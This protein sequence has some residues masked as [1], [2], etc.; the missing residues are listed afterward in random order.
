LR[1]L[2]LVVPVLTGCAQVIGADFNGLLPKAGSGGAA[3]SDQTGGAGGGA[4]D[5][6]SGGGGA[7][8]GGAAGA[9][10]NVMEDASADATGDGA[11][12][13]ATTDRADAKDVSADTMGDGDAPTMRDATTDLI[14]T[15]VA[16]ADHA[17]AVVPPDA[18]VT[19]SVIINEIKGVGSGPDWIELHNPGQ[20]PMV[21]DG[22][23]VAQAMGSTGPPDLVGALTFPQG[24][25]LDGGAFLMVVAQ[26]ATAGGPTTACQALAASCFTVTWG[27]SSAGERMYLLSPASADAA[28]SIVEQ[29]DY[30]A[31]VVAGQTWARAANGTFQVAAPTPDRPNGI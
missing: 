31:T 3:G 14:G 6:V 26:Q 4:G 13:D 30:P 10:G 2:A 17:D 11:A 23:S 12:H 19:G 29:V 7:G 15:D 22:Y 27:V 1:W 16:T 24:T 18:P 9:A 28:S 8:E 5:G 20:M 21:L 25:M